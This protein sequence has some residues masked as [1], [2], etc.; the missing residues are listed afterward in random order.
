M[1]EHNIFRRIAIFLIR[2]IPL[3]IANTI[4][5][6]FS[7]HI[8]QNNI[9]NRTCVILHGILNLRSRNR[10]QVNIADVDRVQRCAGEHLLIHAHLG[11]NGVTAQFS[12]RNRPVSG[13]LSGECAANQVCLLTGLADRNK[14][15]HHIGFY[16]LGD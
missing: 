16:V 4:N 10:G 8:A 6:A 3:T 15:T 14:T 5:P 1:A 9:R 2:L 11:G 12:L 7:G 13:G